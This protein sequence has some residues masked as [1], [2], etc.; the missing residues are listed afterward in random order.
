M[1]CP[2]NFYA[3]GYILP[4]GTRDALYVNRSSNYVRYQ[5]RLFEQFANQQRRPLIGM[6]GGDQTLFSS[7]GGI[8]SPLLGRG[9]RPTMGRYPPSALFSPFGLGIE[10]VTGHTNRFPCTDRSAMR[11]PWLSPISFDISRLPN[12]ASY[13]YNNGHQAWPTNRQSLFSSPSSPSSCFFNDD[14]DDSEDEDGFSAWGLSR[15]RKR[16]FGHYRRTPYGQQ[17]RGNFFDDYD[18]FVD[19]SAETDKNYVHGLYAARQYRRCQLHC[20][21]DSCWRFA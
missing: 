13:Y 9:M 12:T 21:K 16:G 19:F 14:S 2:L 5:E 3:S 4:P 1:S 6:F 18:R 7:M 20:P 15:Q 8:Q 10:T 11:P 17:P